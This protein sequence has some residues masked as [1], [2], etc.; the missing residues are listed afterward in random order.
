MK[1]MGADERN[2]L[3]VRIVRLRTESNMS[4]IELACLAGVHIRTVQSWLSKVS[5]VFD[6][7]E[8]LAEK[9]RGRP[10][11][12]CRK[13]KIEDEIQIRIR[14]NSTMPEQWDLPYYLWTRKSVQHFVMMQYGIYLSKR[15]ARNYLKRWGYAGEQT[16]GSMT[17]KFC[18]PI[19]NLPEIQARA[20]SIQADIYWYKEA[21]VSEDVLW[22]TKTRQVMQL[23]KSRPHLIKAGAPR[24]I[25]CYMQ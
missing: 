8:N 18:K 23:G 15:L 4:C 14:I 17:N 19:E 12:A 9:P 16:H 13:L 5:P 2:A 10:F 3:R 21:V 24:G 7:P 20:G 22:T 6:L 1:K 11:G 25:T